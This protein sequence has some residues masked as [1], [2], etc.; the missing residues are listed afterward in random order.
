MTEST[1]VKT[2]TTLFGTGIVYMIGGIDLIFSVLLTFLV[3]DYVTELMKAFIN[4][5]LSSSIGYAGLMKKVGVLIAIIVAHQVD[6]IAPGETLIRTAVITFFIANEGISL[7]ENLSIIGVPVPDVLV[8][9]LKAW[10]DTEKR[11]VG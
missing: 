2:L 8:R 4:K 11:E 10:K 1:V 5:D 9:A 6:K 7:I 3:L